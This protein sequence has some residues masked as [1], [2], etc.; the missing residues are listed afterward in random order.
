MTLAHRNG[1]KCLC[2]FTDSSD[3]HWSGI[4]TQVSLT[5]LDVPNVEKQHELLAF[6]CGKFNRTE[7]GWSTLEKEVYAILATVQRMHWLLGGP[8]GLDL[9]TDHNNL[10]FIFDPL[11]VVA[12]LSQTTLRKVLRWAVRL[13]AYNYTCVH[14]NVVNNGWVDLLNRW[15]N[16]TP[17]TIRRLVSIPP[18]P[19]LSDSDSVWPFLEQKAA[20]PH[21]CKD[22]PDN[23]HLVDGLWKTNTDAIWVP[24][25]AEDI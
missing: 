18:L 12:D 7:S 10:L 19:S 2:I 17:S 1:T 13:S 14:H 20:V 22:W 4:V 8:D 16:P 5:Y 23:L 9:F 25:D 24:N 11:A 21:S 15:Y 6:P 3:T